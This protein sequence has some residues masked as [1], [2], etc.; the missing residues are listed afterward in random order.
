MSFA[1]AEL[2]K[3]FDEFVDEK[4]PPSEIAVRILACLQEISDTQDSGQTL[5]TLRSVENL[6]RQNE[7]PQ[8]Q[9]KPPLLQSTFEWL[10]KM[11]LTR[12]KK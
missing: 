11:D 2:I 7:A 9:H 8:E 5:F 12:D 10:D 3:N 6:L 4:D 1:V